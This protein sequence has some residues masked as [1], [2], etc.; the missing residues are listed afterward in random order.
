MKFSIIIP[1]HN[2]EEYLNDCIDSIYSQ[3]MT[4]FE[5]IFVVN[6]S[7]DESENIC[8]LAR[9][10][11]SNI[12][13]IVT[14]TVGVSSARNIGLREAQGE[15]IIFVDADDC[16]LPGALAAFEE[17][18]GDGPDVVTANYLRNKTK[19]MSGKV[20]DTDS[21]TY[22]KAMLDPPAFFGRLSLTWQPIVTYCVFAKAFRRQFLAD[23]N[24]YFDTDLAI[25]EDLIFSMKSALCADLI[26]CADEAV[27]Y[28]RPGESTASS[29]QD[30]SGVIKRLASAKKLLNMINGLPDELHREA[31]MK[32]IDIILRSIVI[33][34]SLGAEKKDAYKKILSFLREYRLGKLFARCRSGSLSL[35]SVDENICYMKM[36]ESLREGKLAPAFKTAETYIGFLEKKNRLKQLIH[37]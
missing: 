2:A 27:Y 14:D 8:L 16:L 26:R 22:L 17:T 36:M 23:N 6:A 4:D 3:D 7:N 25:G 18:C 35:V 12:R 1:V 34:A 20:S 31:G 37:R 9:E 13:V 21:A 10:C 29:R 5:I 24:I 30:L 19:R 28:Y 33:G 32:V 11:H 15:Y